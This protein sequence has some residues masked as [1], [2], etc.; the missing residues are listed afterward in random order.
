[1]YNNPSSEPP[2]DRHDWIVRRAPSEAHPNG[3]EVRYIIDYYSD[4]DGDDSDEASFRLDVR[5]A[6]DSF[7]AARLRWK[8]TLQ[9][10]ESGELFAPFYGETNTGAPSP[11]KDAEASV[12]AQ[13]S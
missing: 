4:E 3:E 5:P 6:V 12:R 1:M 8:K 7:A 11:S 2:F 9:E 13:G 10:Y